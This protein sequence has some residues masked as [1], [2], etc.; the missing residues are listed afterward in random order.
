MTG[1]IVAC[2]CKRVT[3]FDQLDSPILPLLCPPPSLVPLLLSYWSTF[4][5]HDIL[6]PHI[7]FHIWEK[8]YDISLS[9]SCLFPLTWCSLVPSIFIQR[10]YGWIKLHCVRILHFLY[11]FIC[12][13]TPR[14]IPDSVIWLLW[15]V[16]QWTWICMYL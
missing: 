9:E 4:C 13:W 8:T 12:W 16:L 14:L 15:I 3:Q 10:T 6:F 7:S 2:W 11:P 1:S 5:F